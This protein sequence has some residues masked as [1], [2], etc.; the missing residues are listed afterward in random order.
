MFF[1]LLFLVLLLLPPY[2]RAYFV[3]ADCFEKAREVE[4]KDKSKAIPLYADAVSWGVPFGNSAKHAQERLVELAKEASGEEKISILRTLKSSLFRNRS[5]F[6]RSSRESLIEWVNIELEKEAR[7]AGVAAAVQYGADSTVDYIVQIIAQIFFW[8]WC[9]LVF[10]SLWRGFTKEGQILWSQFL[11]RI[12][13][14]IMIYF[15]WLY[16]LSFV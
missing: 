5:I 8:L 15:T 6:H 16:L 4:S 10:W 9:S 1:L 14:A 12:A 11:P 3:S 2:L 7:L 13:A